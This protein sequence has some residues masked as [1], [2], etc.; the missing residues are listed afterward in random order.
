MII[1]SLLAFHTKQKEDK[2][3]KKAPTESIT[4]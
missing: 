3:T 1:Y 2:A 4:E